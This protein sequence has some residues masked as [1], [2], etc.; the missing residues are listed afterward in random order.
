M[1]LAIMRI[2]WLCVFFG[3]CTQAQAAVEINQA[4][5]AELEA[6]KGIGPGTSAKLLAERLRATFSNW[7]DLIDRVHGVGPK[8]AV[9]LS[10]A[11]L[12][13]NGFSYVPTTSSAKSSSR[14]TEPLVIAMSP[15]GGSTA[16]AASSSSPSQHIRW[17]ALTPITNQVTSASQGK[18]VR[19]GASVQAQ[20][21][22]SPAPMGQPLRPEGTP[23]L[24]WR[25][26]P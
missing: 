12:L 26:A 25:P 4:T 24:K 18:V 23:P 14:K 2:L 6:I 9:R 20:G 8:T 22:S 13:V 5:Q 16:S 10:A 15:G 1:F 7:D 21:K 11:G 3:L 17:S 19:L